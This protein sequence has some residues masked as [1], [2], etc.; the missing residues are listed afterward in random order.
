MAAYKQAIITEEK[1]KYSV[2]GKTPVLFE[3]VIWE[4]IKNK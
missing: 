4:K 1:M 2:C 3:V